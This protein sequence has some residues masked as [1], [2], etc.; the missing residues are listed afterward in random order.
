MVKQIAFGIAIA[1]G[2]ALLAVIV[3]CGATALEVVA[4]FA[5]SV[6]VCAKKVSS[7]TN[8]ARLAA[9]ARSCLE[10]HATP[11]FALQAAAAV[12]EDHV[13][14][15]S[16]TA[17]D[18]LPAE[19]I[20]QRCV[21]EALQRVK[22]QTAKVEHGFFEKHEL[23]IVRRASGELF[24]LAAPGCTRVPPG[25][26]P[27]LKAE[28]ERVPPAVSAALVE[29][30]PMDEDRDQRA[31]SR[32]DG[33]AGRDADEGPAVSL[34]GFSVTRTNK[35]WR[36]KPCLSAG[37]SDRYLACLCD[38]LVS[39]RRARVEPAWQPPAGDAGRADAA[40]R[41]AQPDGPENVFD[42]E[43]RWLVR[44]RLR[45]RAVYYTFSMLARS[46]REAPWLA[47]CFDP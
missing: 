13:R 25:E 21:V 42:R 23:E 44:R 8:H 22:P 32:C 34:L 14:V 7:T 35:G 5:D 3:R 17:I 11:A 9:A 46:A 20:V 40:R 29:G 24:V 28:R 4:P 16:V 36:C 47:A 18:G 43:R 10:R 33:A 27:Q 45:G 12:I 6:A 31:F 38:A 26:R 1:A 15:V 2:C 30:S 19:A 37:G 39:H 41:A